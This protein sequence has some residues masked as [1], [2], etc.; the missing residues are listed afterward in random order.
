MSTS[1][2]VFELTDC[3]EENITGAIDSLARLAMADDEGG[4]R[5]R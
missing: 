1:A 3:R 2:F 4:H 5:L